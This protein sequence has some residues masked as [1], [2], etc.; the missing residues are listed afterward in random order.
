MATAD[1]PTGHNKQMI[2]NNNFMQETRTDYFPVESA[3]PANKAEESYK[4]SEVKN[5][6]RNSL[7]VNFKEH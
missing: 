4:N 1:N 3:A 5:T 6:Q 7:S 2:Q